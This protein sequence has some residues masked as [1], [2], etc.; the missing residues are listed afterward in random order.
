AVDHCMHTLS[1]HHVL[2][3]QD[4]IKPD[5]IGVPPSLNVQCVSDVLPPSSVTAMDNCDGQVLVTFTITN[6]GG[7]A[8]VF[9]PTNRLPCP[10]FITNVWTAVVHCKNTNIGL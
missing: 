6:S 7:F 1:L 8:D 9:N 3:I 5:L 4:T 10:L 2:P